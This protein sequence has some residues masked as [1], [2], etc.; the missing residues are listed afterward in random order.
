VSMS[1]YVCFRLGTFSIVMFSCCMFWSMVSVGAFSVFIRMYVG[2]IFADCSKNFMASALPRSLMQYLTNHVGLYV[3]MAIFS[4]S[5]R[6]VSAVGFV[7]SILPSAGSTFL[8]CH[9]PRIFRP[10]CAILWA[11]SRF[12]SVNFVS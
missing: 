5:S 9:Q 12:V 7:L 3:F 6:P 10:I 11:F 1:L 2:V 4:V 8:R